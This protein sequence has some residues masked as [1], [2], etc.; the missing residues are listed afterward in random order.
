MK[1]KVAYIST[2]TSLASRL[3]KVAGIELDIRS[4]QEARTLINS[5]RHDVVLLDIRNHRSPVTFIES[6]R[7][8]QP[9]TPIL[10]VADDKADNHLLLQCLCSGAMGYIHQ[11]DIPSQLHAAIVAIQQN[12]AWVPRHIVSH[13]INSLTAFRQSSAAG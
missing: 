4:P 11:I 13:L 5:A 8:W 1:T 6:A 10:L 9:G 3:E 2:D 7:R 12:Q